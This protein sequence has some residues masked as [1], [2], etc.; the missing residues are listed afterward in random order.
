MFIERWRCTFSTPRVTVCKPKLHCYLDQNTAYGEKCQSWHK[1]AVLTDFIQS[2]SCQFFS[3]K[4]YIQVCWLFLTI[5]SKKVPAC[6]RMWLVFPHRSSFSTATRNSTANAHLSSGELLKELN[7]T[8]YKQK[9]SYVIGHH[10][11]MIKANMDKAPKPFSKH[12]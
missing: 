7:V 12:Q 1:M 2:W 3:H 9:S 6:L 11:T 10:P 4:E 8:R 5:L